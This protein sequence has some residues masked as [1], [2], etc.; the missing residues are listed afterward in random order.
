MDAKTIILGGRELTVRP[1]ILRQL[2]EVLP[3]FARA[4]GMTSAGGIDAAIDI[5]AAA[6]S[7]DHPELT[8]EA[9]LELEG[10]ARELTRAVGAVAELSGLVAAGEPPAGS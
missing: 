2:R 4:A 6:L 9:I 7:R 1:L 8:R 3:A 5:V 10:T